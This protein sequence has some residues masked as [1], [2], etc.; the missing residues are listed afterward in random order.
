MPKRHSVQVPKDLWNNLC[1]D[2]AKEMKK[3]R[4]SV[5]PS[6]RLREILHKYF[7]NKNNKKRR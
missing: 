6:S 1:E 4:E 2:A 3:R 7:D 5:T